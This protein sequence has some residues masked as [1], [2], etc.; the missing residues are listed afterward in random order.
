MSKYLRR[1]VVVEVTRHRATTP[2]PAGPP[3]RPKVGGTLHPR[4]SDEQPNPVDDLEAALDAWIAAQE[5][6]AHG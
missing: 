2:R 4:R 3:D 6:K 5:A 1:K